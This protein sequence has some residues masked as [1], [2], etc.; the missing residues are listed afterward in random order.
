M[1]VQAALHDPRFPPVHAGE[2]QDIEIEISVLSPLVP[3]MD[4]AEIEVGRDGL[5]ISLGRASGLLLPQ[6][7][8]ERNWDRET[9]LDQTC[10][11]AGLPAG[12]WRREDV[13]ILRFTAEVFS[14]KEMGL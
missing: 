11:K 5:V 14:E 8:S 4:I 10:V 12:S 7:A 2:V 13:T 6:V 3:V 9:F 1:A